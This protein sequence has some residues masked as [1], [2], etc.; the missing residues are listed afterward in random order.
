M[1]RGMLVAKMM[2]PGGTRFDLAAM[3]W[4]GSLNKETGITV[5]WHTAPHMT[6]KDL[7]DKELIVGG[8]TNVDP[9]TTPKL[10]NAVL[11]TKFKVITGY[12]STA[13]IALAIERGEVQGIGDWSWSSIKA[14][15]PHW[16]RD[17][18]IKLLLQG[19]F[20]KDP[21]LPN[22]PMALDY[23]KSP[24]DRK[25]LELQLVQ[26]TA[27]RPVVAP[28]G[29]PAERVAALRT[30]FMALKADREFLADANK[31][32]LEVELISGAEV[33][34]VVAL[35]SSTPADIVARYVAAVRPAGKK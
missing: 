16:V 28:P 1:Q 18:Q 34:K 22:V 33:D 5:A 35:L 17:K 30:A 6:V 15:R 12:N 27:A 21:E 24:I 11:G 13:Q 2:N 10:Y 20:E 26:K 4:I 3:N 8:I 23:V 14:Q 32:K 7:F 19:A 29:V 9:E 31:S 25:V